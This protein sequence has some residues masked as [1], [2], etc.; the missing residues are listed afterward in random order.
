MEGDEYNG[1]QISSICE[2]ML[3]KHP[4][5]LL[6]KYHKFLWEN[7]ISKGEYNI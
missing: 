2:Q 5:N 6:A 7:K 3:E 4:N 1:K